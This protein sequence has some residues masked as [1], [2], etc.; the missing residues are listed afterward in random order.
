MGYLPNDLFYMITTSKDLEKYITPK[1]IK[2]W[3]KEQNNIKDIVIEIHY[4]RGINE[5]YFSQSHNVRDLEDIIAQTYHIDTINY[6]NDK[7]AIIQHE[8]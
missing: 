8:D 1:I 5:H 2:K 3:Y 6:Y 4:V 7:V